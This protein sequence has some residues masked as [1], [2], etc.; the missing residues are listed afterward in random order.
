[1][2]LKAKISFV[3]AAVSAGAGQEFSCSDPVGNNLIH[4]GYAEKVEQDEGK[5]NNV[6]RNSD[7]VKGRGRVSK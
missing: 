7:A 6:K 1:M 2:K 3:G 4:A 5:P